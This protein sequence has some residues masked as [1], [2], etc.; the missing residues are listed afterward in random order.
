MQGY[1]GFDADLGLT[2][3]VAVFGYADVQGVSFTYISPWSDP[4]T[5]G[6]DTVPWEGDYVTIPA[7]QSIALDVSPPP[8]G[9][10][11]IQGSLIFQDTQVS[12]LLLSAGFSKRLRGRLHSVSSNKCP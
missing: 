8:L 3:R 7:G 9:L 4:A 11:S 10:L 5:W 6:G 2:V 1:P 12:P